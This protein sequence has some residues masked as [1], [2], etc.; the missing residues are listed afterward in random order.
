VGNDVLEYYNPFSNEP[1]WATPLF[2]KTL[3]V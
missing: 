1:H 3:Q 2:S